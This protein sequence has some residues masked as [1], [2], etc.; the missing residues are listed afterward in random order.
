MTNSIHISID[1]ETLDT[2]PSALVLSCGLVAFNPYTGEILDRD[3]TRFVGLD[4]QVARGRTI[5]A[6]TV[7]WWAAQSDEARRVLT[8]S[9]E[10]GNDA[11]FGLARIRD[12]FRKH[13]DALDGVWGNGADFDNAILGSLFESFGQQRPWNYGLNRCLRTLKNLAL[14]KTFV[15]PARVGTHHHALDDA[16]YQANYVSAIVKA[17]DLKL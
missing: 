7:Q 11:A 4:E 13:A 2:K 3:Y 17:L 12:F 9:D 6:A 1:L 14:P 16:E 15:K 8:D 10:F 5:S